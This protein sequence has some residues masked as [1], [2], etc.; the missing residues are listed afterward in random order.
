MNWFM[1][2][3]RMVCGGMVGIKDRMKKANDVNQDLLFK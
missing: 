3:N 2:W 1:Q